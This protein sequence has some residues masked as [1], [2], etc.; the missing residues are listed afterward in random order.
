MA[1]LPK[2]TVQIVGI[3]HCPR[4]WCHRQ[5]N[6]QIASDRPIFRNKAQAP[7]WIIMLDFLAHPLFRDMP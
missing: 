1:G 2:R 7:G 3:Q 4:Q 5:L 6:R